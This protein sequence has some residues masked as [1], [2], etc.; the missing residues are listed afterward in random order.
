LTQTEIDAWCAAS[1]AVLGH[2]TAG[3]NRSLQAMAVNG[4]T[5]IAVGFFAGPHVYNRYDI[6]AGRDCG[7]VCFGLAVIGG[8]VIPTL[9]RGLRP[10]AERNTESVIGRMA[11]F[12]VNKLAP[13]ATGP[14]M[15]GSQ[16]PP[17]PPG[18]VGMTGA[19]GQTGATGPAG[20][21]GDSK[22]EGTK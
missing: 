11:G 13:M 1:G 10:W 3:G 19:T 12:V 21:A 16:G 9:L 17:G 15:A 18:Q 6:A 2:L 5:G 7:G 14:N 4:M 8:L 20:P 22:T